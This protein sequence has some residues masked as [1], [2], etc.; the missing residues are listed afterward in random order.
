MKCRESPPD[1]L[2]VRDHIDI[3][4]SEWMRVVY[5]RLR[6]MVEGFIGRVR[7]RLA[8]GRLT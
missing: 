3:E 5:K 1:V 4:D 6:A 7:C 8:Y 2:S